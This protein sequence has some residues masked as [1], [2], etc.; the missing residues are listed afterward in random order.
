[1]TGS[2]GRCA[3]RTP[4]ESELTCP[5]VRY[6]DSESSCGYGRWSRIVRQLR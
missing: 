5:P 2:S 3:R 1:M 4:K 6:T